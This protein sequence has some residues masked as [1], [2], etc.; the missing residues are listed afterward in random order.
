MLSSMAT[1]RKYSTVPSVASA[2][3]VSLH[4]QLFLILRDQVVRG[5]HPPGGLLPGVESLCE[6]YGVSGITI[7]RALT[8]LATAGYVQRKRG[9][10]TFVRQNVPQ[11]RPSANADLIANLSS[12]SARTQVDVLNLAVATPPLDVAALLEI[13]PKDRAMNAVRRRK[14]GKVPLMVTDAWIPT[15]ISHGV[16]SASL[17]AMPLFKILQARGVSYGR[18]IQEYSAVSADISMARLLACE[19]SSP[20]ILMTRLYYDVDGRPIQYLTAHLSP[21]RSRILMEIPSESVN[22]L[23]GG[24]I[25]HD[26]FRYSVEH[27][28]VLRSSA[29]PAAKKGA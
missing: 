9:L 4:R 5:I 11:V 17:K 14:M 25:V 1:K 29:K 16:S 3:G 26:N 21:E 2:P 13:G 23:S 10:G 18:V 28:D 15:D 24:Q 20:L 8:D 22:A 19:V 12:L 7:R 27:Q 6:E